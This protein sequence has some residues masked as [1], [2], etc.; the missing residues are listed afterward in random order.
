[1]FHFPTP[2]PFEKKKFSTVLLYAK[3]CLPPLPL[4]QH[5]KSQSFSEQAARQTTDGSLNLLSLV[6]E[7]HVVKVCVSIYFTV[8]LTHHA[9]KNTTIPAICLHGRL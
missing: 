7:T 8:V 3:A 2:G 9:N 5:T 4:P 6:A 1:M